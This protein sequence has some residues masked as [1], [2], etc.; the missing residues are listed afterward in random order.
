MEVGTRAPSR[1]APRGNRGPPG[2]GGLG[3]DLAAVQPAP[4]GGERNAVPPGGDKA[5]GLRPPMEGGPAW[6]GASSSNKG[7]PGFVWDM[8]RCRRVGGRLRFRSPGGCRVHAGPGT[9]LNTRERAGPA[10]S[11]RAPGQA[12]P[13]HPASWIPRAHTPGRVQTC[14][15]WGAGAGRRADPGGFLDVPSLGLSF[16]TCRMVVPGPGSGYVWAPRNREL[17]LPAESPFWGSRGRGTKPR[18]L[19]LA[20]EDQRGGRRVAFIGPP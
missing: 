13:L 14:A 20:L 12:W 10:S 18:P 4:G 11:R 2:A 19:C 5:L 3:F 9:P 7:H 1:I 15:R 8:V 17:L 6:S 16:P